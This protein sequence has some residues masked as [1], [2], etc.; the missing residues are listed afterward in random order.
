M[1]AGNIITRNLASQT[2]A[3]Q[4]AE[5]ANRVV[6][7]AGAASIAGQGLKLQALK[8]GKGS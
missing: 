3:R 5:F 6:T 7:G 2:G 1:G 8:Q 4:S